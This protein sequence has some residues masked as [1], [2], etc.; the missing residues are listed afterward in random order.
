MR[1]LR[2]VGLLTFSYLAGC[3]SSTNECVGTRADW[4]QVGESEV[5]AEQRREDLFSQQKFSSDN[6]GTIQWYRDSDNSHFAC[7]PGWNDDGCGEETHKI[8]RVD[9][10]WKAVEFD[11][12]ICTG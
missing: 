10:E 4:L 7:F 2:V 12:I 11:G 6:D 8:I 1:L 3:A 5:P 9:G